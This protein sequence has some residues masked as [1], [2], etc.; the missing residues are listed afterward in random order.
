MPSFYAILKANI[1]SILTGTTG[2]LTGTT[3]LLEEFEHTTRIFPEDTDE[4]VTFTVG[5]VTNT[6][7]AWTEIVDNNGVT[8][9]SKFA[10]KEGHV[11]AMVVE[12]TSVANKRCMSE[13]AYGD[14]KTIISRCRLYTG[15][16][17]KQEARLRGITIPVGEKVYY[18]VKSDQADLTA[19]LHFRYHYHNA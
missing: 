15:S 12:V 13:L 10:L 19:V 7:S 8:F 9:S 16:V 18:R 14:A 1:T 2:I 3:E 4:T 17:P 5:A 11:S 6:W